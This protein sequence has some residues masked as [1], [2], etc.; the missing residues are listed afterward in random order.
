MQS[1]K[2][3]VDETSSLPPKKNCVSKKIDVCCI[4]ET[5]SMDFL[6]LG[7]YQPKNVK[8]NTQIFVVIDKFCNFGWTVLLKKNF[9]TQ[10]DSFEHIRISAKKNKFD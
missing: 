4:D 10:L 8:S 6:D 1:D 9:V 3:F 7:D 2:V 5:W